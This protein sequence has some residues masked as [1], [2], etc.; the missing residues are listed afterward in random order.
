[1]LDK[2]WVGGLSAKLVPEASNY[3]IDFLFGCQTSETGLFRTQLADGIMGMANADDTLPLQLMKAGVTATQMFALCFRIGGG[4]MTLGGVDQRIH[5]KSGIS[6]AKMVRSS[7]GWFAVEL[8]DI[9]LQ[10]QRTSEK[11]SLE[12][13]VTDYNGGKGCII[14][15]GT[16][17]TYLPQSLSKKFAA[18]FKQISGVDYSSK[19]TP[20]TEAQL[21][22]MP[23]VIYTLRGTNNETFEVRYAC[24]SM[25]VNM[26]SYMHVLYNV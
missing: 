18:M 24:I 8:V 22:K 9:S 10:D 21:E 15:S 23:N 3:A 20:L 5:L 11:S 13:D 26:N 16:T 14:D 19:N 7:A 4:I 2:L 1:V 6:Y 17:D 12:G 25:Y